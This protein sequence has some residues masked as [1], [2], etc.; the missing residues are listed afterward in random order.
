MTASFIAGIVVGVTAVG[1]SASLLGSSVFPDVPSNAYYN[2]AVGTLNAAGIVRGSNGKFRPGDFVTRA[3]VAVMIARLRAELT[4]EPLDESVQPST[5]NTSSAPSDSGQTSSTTV[6]VR[7]SSKSSSVASSS[8]KSSSSSSA[9]YNPKGSLHFTTGGFTVGEQL[10]KI[11][12]AVVR[13]GGSDGTAGI[14][15]TVTAGTATAGIDFLAASGTLIFSNKE[16]NKNFTVTIPDDSLGEGDETFIVT[17]SNP[18]HGVGLKAPSTATVTIKDNETSGSSTSSSGTAGS[19]S[20]GPVAGTFNLSATA[21]AIREDGGSL[22][23]T[24]N[25]TGGSQGAVSVAYA[26]ANGSATSG[27]DYNATSGTLSFAAGETSKTFTVTSLNNESITG[28]KAFN[29]VLSTPSGGAALGTAKQASVT[30]YDDESGSF[31]SGS[32]KFN[33]ATYEVTQSQGSIEI[34]VMRIGGANGTINV[35]YSTGNGSAFAGVDYTDTQGTLTFA[36]GE[37]SKTFSIPIRKNDG[38]GSE[39]TINLALTNPTLPAT[40]INPYTAVVTIYK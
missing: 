1:A 13:T 25:R 28:N 20:A 18:Q 39:R 5:P 7:R 23:V 31:G 10:G 19:S 26:T 4:G 27:T 9:G 11:T 17:L 33:K 38:G 30:I 40:L 24:V 2:T 12:L 8:L 22:N 36:P 35:S 6:T 14:S 15:Y 32:L 29:I 3:D 16:T 21:Y 34:T 37:A